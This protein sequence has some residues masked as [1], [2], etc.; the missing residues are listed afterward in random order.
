MIP[1]G[2]KAPKLSNPANQPSGS[3]YWG[4]SWNEPSPRVRFWG[5]WRN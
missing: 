5:P 2:L 3:L 4:H 1:L